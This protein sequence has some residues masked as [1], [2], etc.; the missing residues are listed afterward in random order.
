MIKVINED[1]FYKA[2]Y[3]NKKMHTIPE[4]KQSQ[5]CRVKTTIYIRNKCP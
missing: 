2:E 4:G 5:K 3:M 1:Y